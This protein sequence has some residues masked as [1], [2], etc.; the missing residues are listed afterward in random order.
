MLQDQIS[1]LL[2]E[3]A[4]FTELT[5]WLSHQIF[6]QMLVMIEHT[7]DFLLSKQGGIVLPA[8]N[9]TFWCLGNSY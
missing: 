8:H 7:L 9:Q 5:L 4:Q 3:Q 6:Q 1:L 2:V